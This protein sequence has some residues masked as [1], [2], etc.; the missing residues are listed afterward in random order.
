[1]DPEVVPLAELHA[2]LSCVTVEGQA[3][4][5]VLIK[6]TIPWSPFKPEHTRYLFALFNQHDTDGRAI[7]AL[8]LTE[9]P[10]ERL[11]SYET[12]TVTGA[13]IPVTTDVV[14]HGTEVQIGRK[15]NYF[16]EDGMVLIR[17]DEIAS[18]GERWVRGASTEASNGSG[19]EANV[20]R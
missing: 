9:R 1:M 6:Q 18:D 17:A 20:T 19:G 14:P 3:H 11:V 2:D 5:E 13:L 12:M 7:R 8:V 16:F 15:A 10:P 4:Y